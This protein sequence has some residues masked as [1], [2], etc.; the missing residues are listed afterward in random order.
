[1]IYDP[2]AAKTCTGTTTTELEQQVAFRA[3][4]AHRCYDQA[5]A[6]DS[7]LKG[8]VALKVR[9]GSNGAVCSAVVTDNDMGTDAVANCVANTFRASRSLPAPKGNCAEVNVPISFVPGGK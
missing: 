8:H 6:N 3:K 7:D 1:M 9:V 4:T 2:C 5:L